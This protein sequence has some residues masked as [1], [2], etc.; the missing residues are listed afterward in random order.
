MRRQGPPALVLIALVV[1]PLLPSC[2]Q[3]DAPPRSSEETKLLNDLADG[4]SVDLFMFRGGGVEN[5][6]LSGGYVDPVLDIRLT[7]KKDFASCSG[8]IRSPRGEDGGAK[9]F[10]GSDR[11]HVIDVNRSESHVETQNG[12]SCYDKT[13]AKAFKLEET[14][15]GLGLLPKN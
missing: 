5:V 1:L 10:V 7:L 8:W 6:C 11:C 2:G 12:S 4:K 3:D 14:P 9:I 13:Q 15:Y